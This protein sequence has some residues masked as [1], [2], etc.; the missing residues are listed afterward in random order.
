MILMLLNITTD[1]GYT[2][3]NGVTDIWKSLDKFQAFL[4][5]SLIYLL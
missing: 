4:H 1:A 2:S 3:V 5:H